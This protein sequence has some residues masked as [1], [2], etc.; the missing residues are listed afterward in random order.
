MTI[1]NRTHTLSILQVQAGIALCEITEDNAPTQDDR[2]YYVVGLDAAQGQVTSTVPND[3]AQEG[4]WTA[5]RTPSGVSYV[6]SPRTIAN[7]R[8]WFRRLVSEAQQ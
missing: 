8:R 4:T 1:T 3:C 6:A 2:R 5:S 7:A